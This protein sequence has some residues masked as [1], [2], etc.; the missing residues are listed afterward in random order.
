MINLNELAYITEVGDCFFIETKKNGNFICLPSS[1]KDE[2]KVIKY[3]EGGLNDYTSY[4][5]FLGE[6]QIS[7]IVGMSPTVLQGEK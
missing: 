3:F 7:K 2:S 6:I 1:D 4:G 5:K